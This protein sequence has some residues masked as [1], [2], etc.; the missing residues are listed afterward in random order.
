MPAPT[1][2]Q[3][4]PTPWSA[5]YLPT[6]VPAYASQMPFSGRAR[7]QQPIATVFVALAAV[8]VLV[9]GALGTGLIK[10]PGSNSPSGAG[11]AASVQSPPPIDNLATRV[12]GSLT[13]GTS[14]SVKSIEIAAGG[15]STTV[16]APGK[17]WNGL[18]LDVPAGAWTGSTLA[19]TA[20]TI[21]GSSY[22]DLITPITPLY[23]VSGAEGMAPAPVS[24]KI[25]ATIPDDSFAMGFFYDTATGNLEGMPLV[26]EDATSLTVATE[27]FSSYFGGSVKKKKLPETIDSGFR[28]G[29]DDWQFENWGSYISWD[30]QCAG[31][32]L[33]EAWYYLERRKK[34]TDAPPLYGL[35]DDNGGTK[36]PDLWQDDVKGVRLANVAQVQFDAG[37]KT[38]AGRNA[39]R[40]W[41]AHADRL[42]Y[43]A[44]RYNMKTTDEPQL[45]L[46]WD[47]A[48]T[49]G[50]AMIVYRVSPSG[51]FVADPNYPGGYRLVPFN[52]STGK[53]GTYLSASNARDIAEGKGTTYALFIF[54]AKT[55]MVDWATLGADWAAFDAGT[56][57]NSQFP[58]YGL[59]VLD[60]NANWVPL[61]DGYKTADSTLDIRVSDTA[62]KGV[63]KLSVY[64]GTSSKATQTEVTTASINLDEGN[65]PLGILVKGNKPSEPLSWVDFVRLT[66]V[67]DPSAPKVATSGHWHKTDTVPLKGGDGSTDGELINRNMEDGSTPSAQWGAPPD[68][69]SP[70]GVW[71]TKLTVSA[72]ATLS[73]YCD[74][75]VGS[76]AHHQEW[77]INSAG[78]KDLT[79]TF[80]AYASNVDFYGFVVKATAG[81]MSDTWTYYY[82][83][84]KE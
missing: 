28:P 65:N 2:T 67:Y 41:D 74:Y 14:S 66:V 62:H 47:A 8:V 79:F 25:P 38:Q 36:T 77:V 39:T 69:I 23:T 19:I 72:N 52:S 58:T 6:S 12:S 13:L 50:H 9:A 80:P 15:A 43:D 60:A 10:L 18:E 71:S 76:V 17:A 3:A 40:L 82:K 84:Q 11:P 53:F 33:T 20:Q 1:F 29:K 64:R 30:G 61:T 78:S 73:V 5:P 49:V 57:G 46:I 48:K 45:I 56:I 75:Y 21:T 81:D 7:R 83:W 16:S 55:A 26:A 51:L 35:Y 4:P 68:N 59:Q 54:A 32:S 42:Q 34:D 44:F 27:H 22:G 31:Q 24:I 63:T 37:G 70:G